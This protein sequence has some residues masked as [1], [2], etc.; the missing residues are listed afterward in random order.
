MIT[1]YKLWDGRK[2]TVEQ[3]VTG[4]YAQIGNGKRKAITS[5][6]YMKIVMAGTPC[7]RIE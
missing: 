3:T 4:I 2:A 5:T 6:D 7:D 1:H